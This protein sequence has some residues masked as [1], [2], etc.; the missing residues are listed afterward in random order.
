MDQDARGLTERYLRH[1]CPIAWNTPERLTAYAALGFEIVRTAFAVLR[2]ELRGGEAFSTEALP[3]GLSL[4][5]DI[6]AREGAPPLVRVALDQPRE[7][8]MVKSVAGETEC[9]PAAD[10]Y[11]LDEAYLDDHEPINSCD[12]PM[13]YAYATLG[14]AAE[15]EIFQRL[16]A[17]PPDRP[18]DHE[19]L[20]VTV[21]T[22][23]TAGGC[24]VV[25]VGSTC[26]HQERTDGNG[27]S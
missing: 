25:C 1:Y 6:A 9:R 24:A 13:R 8:A 19:R 14:Y 16:L 27:D 21:D 2:R 5:F 17:S 26:M 3:V 23:K 7:A 11:P 15:R 10:K 4:A 12:V 18:T 20:D 22:T